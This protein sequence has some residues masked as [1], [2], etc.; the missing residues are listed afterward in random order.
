MG[1]YVGGLWWLD[2]AVWAMVTRWLRGVITRCGLC[3]GYAVWTMVVVAMLVFEG[4]DMHSTTGNTSTRKPSEKTP[5]TKNL[6]EK[7]PRTKTFHEKT[8][9]TKTPHEKIPH[10]N[11]NN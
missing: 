7:I 10:D 9:H 8:P 1:R 11:S 3:D 2:Y 6:H 5:H 4:M